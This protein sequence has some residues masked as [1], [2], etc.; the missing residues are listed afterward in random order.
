MGFCRQINVATIMKTTRLTTRFTTGMRV[1]ASFAVVLLILAAMTVLAV[2]RL[3]AADTATHSLVNDSMAKRQLSL[4]MLG[5]AKLNGVRAAAIARSDSLEVGDYFMAQLGEG[6]RE[7]ALLAARIGKQRLDA[8]EQA[9][10]KSLQAQAQ[11]YAAVRAEVL[12]LKDLGKTQEVALLADT[13]MDAAFKDY[14]GAIVK[15]L[16]YQDRETASVAQESARQFVLGR[17][18]LIGLGVLAL[19][20][21]AALAWLLTRSIVDPLRTALAHILRVADG[22]L[23]PLH[24][25]ARRDEIGRLLDALAGMTEKLA[26]TVGAVRA[27]ALAVDAAAGAL[28]EGS[29]DLAQRTGHQARAL[30]DTAA[31]IDGLG[32]AVRDNSLH[33]READ[34]LAR[35]AFD[36][37]GRGGAVVTEV[38]DTMGA[39]SGFAGK[40]VDITAVIDGIAFQTNL[41]AL[42]AA[43]EAARA[44][45]QGRGFAVVAGEVRSLAQRT[46]VAAREIKL[47]ITDSARQIEAGN[48]KAQA[49]GAT[50]R[51]MLGS[52][53]QVTDIMG[54][55]GKAGAAQEAGI[56]HIGAAVADMD[57]VTRENAALVRQSAEAAQAM[58]AQAHRLAD[59]VGWFRVGEDAGAGEAAP[60]L[61]SSPRA[62]AIS[63]QATSLKFCGPSG[64]RL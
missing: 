61:H 28:A 33:A 62:R 27:S 35:S 55:V 21:G 46:S 13:T 20:A 40:I 43:V 47:L 10:W 38:V 11:S 17:S 37:A 56:V 64:S 42:N 24:H 51:D 57:T 4:D 14:I 2:W 53:S 19:L 60:V 22:D 34:A 31:A 26:A 1:V 52:A 16:A 44:G 45:E 54:K 58:T 7:Q 32:A 36:V 59:M 25:T 12:R 18:L 50:M 41:L 5:L 63:S 15:L 9:L 8:A 29:A 49:A 39:I 3:Q 30:G 6:D 48:R 23:Q